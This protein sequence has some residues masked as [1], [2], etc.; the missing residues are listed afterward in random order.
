P[1]GADQVERILANILL[2]AIE[3][4]GEHPFIR[5]STSNVRGVVT[6]TVFD[7]GNGMSQE[8]VSRILAGKAITTKPSGNG[9]GLASCIAK[10]RAVAG[11][12]RIDSKLGL[13]T[14]VDIKILIDDQSA[15]KASFI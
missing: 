5:I 6:I 14:K 1:I 12:L 13:G 8:M 11:E 9:I 2:N 15:K 3:A 4:L 7:N 10:L